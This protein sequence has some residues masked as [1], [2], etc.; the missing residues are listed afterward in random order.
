MSNR[1]YAILIVAFFAGLI[2]LWW[3]E[4]AHVPDRNARRLAESRILPGLWDARPDDVQKVV[5]EGGPK[6]I[7]FERRPGHRWQMVEPLD[8]AADPSF[9]ENLAF[10]LKMLEKVRD[11][12]TIGDDP[13]AY[14]LKPPS[15]TIKLYGTSGTEPI[16]TLEV[17]A[18]ATNR[19]RRYVRDASDPGIEV[20]ESAKL[21]SV[22][23]P[24]EHWR[25]RMLVRM[26]S[27]DVQSLLA[28][29]SSGEALEV[30]RRGPL[31]AL[32]RPFV[33]VADESRVE[34]LL[35]EVSGLRVPDD[36]FVADDVRDFAPYG[37]DKDK[38]L[39]RIKLT[40][41]GNDPSPQTIVI[42]KA[43]PV[44]ETEKDKAKGA[45]YYARRD[46]QDDVV[47][48]DAGLLKDLGL[49][50]TD[51]HGKKV[52]DLDPARV[53]AIRLRSEDATV[54][55]AKRQRGW[56][57]VEPLRDRADAEAIAALLKK[58][59]EAEASVLF[60]PNTAPDAQV[61]K[62]WATLELWQGS[63]PRPGEGPASSPATPPRIKLA[64]GRRDA[65]AKTVFAQVEGDPVILA[66]PISFLDGMTFGSLAF[67]D[68]Q[69]AAASP[70][71]VERI[72]LV[73]G[74][75]RVV[76]EAPR[77]ANPSSWRL[78][79]PTEAPADPETVGRV[80]HQLSNLRAESLVTDRPG[81]DEKFGLD[82]P[83][84]TFTWK[85][86]DQFFPPPRATIEGTEATL[87][88][89]GEVPNKPDRPRYARVSTSP[90]VF[91]IPSTL[92][93]QLEAE[94]RDRT[95]LSFPP[96]S[97]ERITLRWPG[98]TL[99]ARPVADASAAEPDW[100]LVDPP[101]GLKLDV[102]QLKP[103]AKTL[104]KLT[105]FRYAQHSGPIPPETGLFPARLEVEVQPTGAVRPLHLRVGRQTPDGY[106][107]ATT[108]DTP[109]GAV[110]LLPL[111]NWN[112]WLKP[113]TIEA[114]PAMEAK[115][116]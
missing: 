99:N 15:R 32:V 76:V 29:R 70:P 60:A 38:P 115:P 53:D 45:R 113:P 111:S 6:R 65:V 30:E 85:L 13:S 92:V 41:R 1:G 49:H 24:A 97:A 11:A 69:V 101:V 55:V 112:P 34:G 102:S 8:A 98:L 108:E 5:I 44:T 20:V 79:E 87:A 116:K 39:V 71:Q 9:V 63:G 109:S 35:A 75:R 50:P 59:D 78:K 93:A 94:W 40:P 66:L 106:L 73:Q 31:W 72:T 64:L 12:G 89:G 22:E 90:I 48:V 56:D 77:D 67:R 18:V 26:P 62:P 47:T 107:Y 33:A 114:E 100:T 83:V 4:Y 10:N 46:D 36:G 17:G 7:T 61:D 42:G 23:L 105:T 14:G 3:A 110:F 58:L 21:A 88:I 82:K 27:N 84:L 86:R 81:S 54:T 74:P 95:V 80:L 52:A 96:K 37:L 104:S 57:R 19:D 103:L 43:A 28:K 2:G 16:A 25:D 51:L 68:R 91:T